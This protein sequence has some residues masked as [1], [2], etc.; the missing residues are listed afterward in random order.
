MGRLRNL[1]AAV[2]VLAGLAG[3]TAA[4]ADVQLL[5][6]SYDPTRELY[7]DDQR[8]LRASTGRPRPARRSR[9]SSRTAARASRRAP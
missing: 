8:G 5:N 4:R 6:V 7:Q 2:A 3:T 1:S 9:S